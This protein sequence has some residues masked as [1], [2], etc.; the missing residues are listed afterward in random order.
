M[1]LDTIRKGRGI[2]KELK[3]N[4]V[5]ALIWPVI[6]YGAEGWTLKNDDERQ[7]ET[8]EMWCYRKLL[9]ISWTEKIPNKSILDE[10]Q[11]S[12]ELLVQI[13]KRKIAHRTQ[14]RMFRKQTTS[15]PILTLLAD[16]R[17]RVDATLVYQ[18]LY[19]FTVKCLIHINPLNSTRRCEPLFSY[20]RIIAWYVGMLC[21][22]QCVNIK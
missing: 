9:W 17:Q 3:I 11:T 13:I 16:S 20:F 22:K 8:A 15:A 19:F 5:K 21:N 10:L 12:R 6:T 18:Y 4:L 1:E 2:R 14:L 7:L